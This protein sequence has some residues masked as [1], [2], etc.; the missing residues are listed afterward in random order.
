VLFRSDLSELPNIEDLETLIDQR[1]T[2]LLQNMPQPV[3]DALTDIIESV[4]PDVVQSILNDL[5]VGEN[6]NHVILDHLP[7]QAEI[8]TFA[9]G[10]I[11]LVYDPNAPFEPEA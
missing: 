7:T 4:T 3:E 5:G 1:I 8:N 6:A 9:A 2:D 10:A 11:V